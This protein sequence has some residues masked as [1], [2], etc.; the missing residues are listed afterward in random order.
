[1]K[2]HRSFV[3]W[4]VLT[5]IALFAGALYLQ[6]AL[7]LQAQVAL[8]R[9]ESMQANS[10][11]KTPLLIIFLKKTASQ[12]QTD[13]LREELKAVPNTKEVKYISSEAAF[14]EYKKQNSN[15]PQLIALVKPDTLPP[16]IEVYTTA[17][18]KD[19]QDTIYNIAHTKP[20]VDI[21]VKSPALDSN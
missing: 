17:R 12:E 9:Q 21:I 8:Q 3:L 11:A 2:K 20:F 14:E 13:S 1:M 18:S 7:S 5:C 6:K 16:S 15:N 19:L 4:G 10:A